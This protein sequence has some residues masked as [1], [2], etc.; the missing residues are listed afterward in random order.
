[1]VS[2]AAHGGGG[3]GGGA[4][5][6]VTA[7]PASAY[8]A[9][10]VNGLTTVQTE[11]VTATPVGG[12]SPYSYLWSVVSAPSG[13][14]TITTPTVQTTRFAC[15]EVDGGESYTATFKCTVTD[16][17]GSVVASNNVEAAVSNFG[18]PL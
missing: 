16:G 18:T 7:A 13:D 8:G 2:P 5:Y 1:M 17:T 11:V 9:R 6:S 12:V 14:W 3:G 15:A 10:V 4:S